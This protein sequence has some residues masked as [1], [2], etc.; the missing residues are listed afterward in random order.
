MNSAPPELK[1]PR[2]RPRSFDR[3]AALGRAME[4]FWERGY[5]DTSLDDLTR[6]MRINPSS[7]YATFGD[8]EQLY[9]A[10]LRCYLTHSRNHIWRVLE[11]K[12]PTRRAL[13]RLLESVATEI[14][15]SGQPSGCMLSLAIMQGS[16][17]TAALR[18]SIARLRK[19]SLAAV[20]SRIKHGIATGDMPRRSNPSAL[21]GFFMSVLQGMSV[22]ARDG[23]S[24]R[25]LIQIARSAMRAFEP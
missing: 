24:R 4:L 21:A 9:R 5:E 11:E 1:R 10:A 17:E 15:R 8:K 14:T 20:H 22:Q 16:T 6:V 25:D 2:G 7:L 12:I 18:A 19:K 3:D 13:G 23:A